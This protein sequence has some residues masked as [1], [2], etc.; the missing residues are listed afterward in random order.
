[1]PDDI[2]GVDGS[3]VTPVYRAVGGTVVDAWSG[4]TLA[5]RADTSAEGL[6]RL[7]EEAGRPVDVEVGR[8]RWVR[9]WPDGCQLAVREP[10]S[11]ARRRALD[12]RRR[13]Q[14]RRDRRRAAVRRALALVWRV[15]SWPPGAVAGCGRALWRALPR[16]RRRGGRGATGGRGALRAR[17]RRARRGRGVP[18]GLARA[19]QAGRPRPRAS[20][21]RRV[22]ARQ[23]R[24]RAASLRGL[25]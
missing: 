10:A 16:R 9:L 5:E 11:I 19:R 25:R 4:S 20:Y 22:T 6:L 1:M 8:G 24:H 17:V 21:G 2:R 7:A 12:D 3:L 13:R 14:V 23:R 18:A 15:V